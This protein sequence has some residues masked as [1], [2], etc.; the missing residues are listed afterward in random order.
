MS[1]NPELHLSAELQQAIANVDIKIAHQYI[2]DERDDEFRL[3]IP[4]E[5]GEYEVVNSKT[6]IQH[7]FDKIINKYD[8]QSI[9]NI[10][11]ASIQNETEEA[12][13]QICLHIRLL[14]DA[15]MPLIK[16]FK[17]DFFDQQELEQFFE[18]VCEAYELNK[19][20]FNDQLR[21]VR[22]SIGLCGELI[23]NF[24]IVQKYQDLN[25]QMSRFD[26]TIQG[27]R[28]VKSAITPFK[29]TRFS[30][31]SK[32]EVKLYL[33]QQKNELAHHLI[34]F[35]ERF[36]RFRQFVLDMEENDFSLI[37]RT[38]HTEMLEIVTQANQTVGE[39]ML[40]DQYRIIQDEVGRE[41]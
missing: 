10:Q 2:P 31:V 28:K 5:E 1:E 14:N 27:Y 37:C 24:G 11:F 21:I 32:E 16:F 20:S 6:Q 12:Y 19:D 33:E 40:Y 26:G 34:Y 36:Q 25:Q 3:K 18:I 38:I 39:N 15:A 9:N 8:S 4:N 22:D 17:H 7:F 35:K 41:M 23:R 29:P 30:D 13:E